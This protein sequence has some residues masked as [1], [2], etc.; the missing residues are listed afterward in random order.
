MANNEPTIK[1]PLAKP[2]E[3][4]IKVRAKR[5][6]EKGTFSGLEV[7][8]VESSNKALEGLKVSAPFQGGG[9]M[10]LKVESLKGLSIADGPADKPE[11]PT[12]KLF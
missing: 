9:S 3:F 12:I 6:S 7:L 1:K 11:K 8:S 10:Y 2:V 4:T 5:I